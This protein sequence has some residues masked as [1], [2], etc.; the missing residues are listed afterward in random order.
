MSQITDSI[1]RLQPLLA[2]ILS[3]KTNEKFNILNHHYLVK[4][5]LNKSEFFRNYLDGRSIREKVVLESMIALGLEDMLSGYL[6][7]WEEQKESLLTLLQHLV[8]VEAFYQPM[9]GLIGYH[10]KV[11][12]LMQE[13]LE[14][15]ECKLQKIAYSKPTGL[16]LSLD[17]SLAQNAAF[18]GLSS[19][20]KMGE[21]YPVGGAGDR[22]GL[23]C[24]KSGDALPAAC[25]L[26]CGKTLL[27]GLIRDLQAREYLFYKIYRRQITVPV[28]LMTSH[29]K[30]N[31]KRIQGIFLDN[32]W[33]G[34]KRE[35]FAFFVQPLVPV[36]TTEG[37]WL[38]NEGQLVFK[39][40]GHGVIWK[41]AKD[42][43]I[44]SWFEKMGCK[45]TLIRQINNPIVGIDNT[46]LA[47]V[48][49]GCSKDKA[50]GLLSCKRLVGSAEGVLV[51]AEN[52]SDAHFKYKITN[53][54]YTDFKKHSIQDLPEEENSSYS[55]FPSN[56]N[57]LF[58]D[59]RKVESALD[60]C[61]VPGMLVN[62]KKVDG[63]D[64]SACRLESTMQNIV[65][66]IENSFSAA[67]SQ[68]EQEERLESY[69]VYNERHKTISVTKNSYIPD[70]RFLETPESAFYDLITNNR[71][72]LEK[73]CLVQILAKEENVAD[74]FKYGP[75][76][77]FLYHPALGPLYSIIKQKIRGGVLHD[78]AELQLEIAEVD[79]ENM[80]LDGSLLISSDAVLGRYDPIL[81]YDDQWCG[82]CTLHNVK[83]KNQGRKREEGSVWENQ[84]ERKG[85]LEIKL[86]G[87]AEFVAENVVF[88]GSQ[89][90]IVENGQKV[91]AYEENG[92]INLKVEIINRPSWSWHYAVEGHEII[93]SKNTF[94][95]T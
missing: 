86:Y 87:N 20:E 51:L 30:E 59:I 23:T 60:K 13:K 2:T 75:Y 36:I 40:G 1:A 64:I 33:F 78:F 19:L 54:E 8:E 42:F 84:I 45:K 31:H 11:L 10:L 66:Y 44:F 16:D 90:I 89:T 53:L 63:R 77:L 22:L 73:E 70:K 46:L 65:D 5:F 34:R 32:N 35:S 74:Y 76:V 29:E 43:G 50:F 37:N 9:G 61:F 83:V 58:A 17:L 47:F 67:L 68:K 25:L 52:K 49:V 3:K 92:I 69:V 71:E 91:T 26:F 62:I 88:L 93:L 7:R 4:N 18:C 14:P 27:E 56:T 81:H 12:E 41:L 95:V 94:E 85:V 79:I 38:T 6:S 57:V 24:S 21:I 72:L 80:E 55:C 39:P 82:R 15:K 48:G 28:A